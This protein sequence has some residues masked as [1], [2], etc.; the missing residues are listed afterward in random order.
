MGWESQVSLKIFKNSVRRSNLKFLSCENRQGS[1][2][3]RC[4]IIKSQIFIILTLSSSD[5]KNQSDTIKL[6][7]ILP[8]SMEFWTPKAGTNRELSK[9]LFF[10]LARFHNFQQL[11]P[12]NGTCPPMERLSDQKRSYVQNP[13]WHSYSLPLCNDLSRSV[14]CC[15]YSVCDHGIL[16]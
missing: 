3:Y 16:D 7:M 12:S 8:F 14:S 1:N 15:K 4:D 6:K 10:F 9:I 2:F 5:F 11:F 13:V